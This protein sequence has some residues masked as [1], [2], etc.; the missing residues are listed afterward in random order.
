M[1]ASL[2]ESRLPALHAGASGCGA[3]SGRTAHS[4]TRGGSCGG[5]ATGAVPTS[6][7]ALPPANRCVAVTKP[8]IAL[9]PAVGANES[10]EGTALSTCCFPSRVVASTA[11][12]RDG[13]GTPHPARFEIG[14]IGTSGGA[15][16]GDCTGNGAASRPTPASGR[17]VALGAVAEV[18]PRERT[19]RTE[20]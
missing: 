3:V 8:L 12:S 2:L 7:A 9:I 18:A 15:V 6:A 19:L 1:F 4:A 17:R 5:I 13:G 16:R 11:D 20:P 14:L 10:G